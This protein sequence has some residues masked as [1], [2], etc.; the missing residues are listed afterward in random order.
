MHWQDTEQSA[1]LLLSLQK[2][3]DQRD[4]ARS[5]R[6]DAY[7]ERDRAIGELETEHEL[8][9]D[10]V[11]ALQQLDNKASTMVLGFENTSKVLV[12]YTNV[13]ETKLK[14]ITAETNQLQRHAKSVEERNRRQEQY[15][16]GLLQDFQKQRQR[17][18]TLDVRNSADILK[19][20]EKE[21]AAFQLMIDK[22]QGFAES[23][24]DGHANAK[25][26]PQKLSSTARTGNRSERKAWAPIVPTI[27]LG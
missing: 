15:I 1:A 4:E 23:C 11:A 16:E 21:K 18:T 6:K 20:K 5:Q 26:D 24:S 3:L 2:A 13:L 8:H 22:L 25:V 10:K 27:R 9:M 17:Y 7:A 12:Q 14:V 19:T